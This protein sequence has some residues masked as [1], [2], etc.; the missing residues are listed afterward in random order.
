MTEHRPAD[1]LV[2]AAR[3]GESL[4]G[5]TR[6]LAAAKQALE[7]Q[8][9]AD[10]AASEQRDARLTRYGRANRW[11]IWMLAVSLV[12]DLGLSVV[13]LRQN[14]ALR[15]EVLTSCF[16]AHDLAPAPVGINPQT[17]KASILGV[18]IVADARDQFVKLGCPGRLSAPDPS[19][20][21]WAH[22]YR[23]PVAR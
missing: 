15:H 22:Y 14:H 19:F 18:R 10:R 23:V 3:L 2:T 4:D 1:A 5:M 12:F 13:Y 17:H 8:A 11:R 16:Q 21:R 9:A 20:V 7:N 6:E